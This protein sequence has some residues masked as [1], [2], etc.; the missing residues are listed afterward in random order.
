MECRSKLQMINLLGKEIALASP[1][2]E[3][4][5][6]QNTSS[7]LLLR[8]ELRTRLPKKPN[9][10]RS[11]RHRHSEDCPDSE[12]MRDFPWGATGSLKPLREIGDLDLMFDAHVSDRHLHYAEPFLD[13]LHP[14]Q[15]GDYLFIGAC[16]CS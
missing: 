3:S 6:P 8:S 5:R 9:I 14:Y 2:D 16:D 10:R 1:K 11:P 15:L 12:A 13:T 4:D 7:L